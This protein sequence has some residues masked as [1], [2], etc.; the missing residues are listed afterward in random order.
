MVDF[1]ME[2]SVREN[3]KGQSCKNIQSRATG[4]FRH[5]Q[6]RTKTNNLVRTT[7]F[8]NNL[9]Q[10][11]SKPR[12][13]YA[14]SQQR[15]LKLSATRNNHRQCCNH[16]NR[17]LRY[18][19]KYLT[20]PCNNMCVVIIDVLICAQRHFQQY[21]FYIIATISSGTLKIEKTN[22]KSQQRKLKLSATWNNHR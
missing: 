9:H 21:V 10:V 3:R 16:I 8:Q 7:R 18:A 14:K 1:A 12:K 17:H 11:R 6:H 15:K 13:K 19:K 2:I 22:K 4:N 20:L 5:A